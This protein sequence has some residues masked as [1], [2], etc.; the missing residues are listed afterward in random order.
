MKNF[1]IRGTVQTLNFEQVLTKFYPLCNKFCNKM[2]LDGYDREDLMQV[3]QISLYRA[4][5]SYDASKNIDFLTFSYNCINNEFKRLIRDSKSLKRNTDNYNFVSIN[6]KSSQNSE[7][8][9]YAEV[10]PD[11]IDI[12]NEV[13]NSELIKIINSCLT[14]D[15]KLIIPVLMGLKTQKQ[16]GIEVGI[17]NEGARKRCNKL[18]LKLK[19]KLTSKGGK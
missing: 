12:E 8:L 10:I 7:S 6:D 14:E 2:F 15:E 9:T 19:Q 1:L 13:M 18:Q 3:C 5:E 16:Y 4:Y 11:K 17:S